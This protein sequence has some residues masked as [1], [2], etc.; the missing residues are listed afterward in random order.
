MSESALRTSAGATVLRFADCAYSF[1]LE[2]H[3]SSKDGETSKGEE[4]EK[5]RRR[6]GEEK[7]GQDSLRR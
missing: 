3:I 5:G 4:G 7:E 2:V 1:A 6:E